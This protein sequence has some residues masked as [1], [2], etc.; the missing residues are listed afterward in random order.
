MEL[1]TI[2]SHHSCSV[3]FLHRFPRILI[4]AHT[5]ARPRAGNVPEHFRNMLLCERKTCNYKY[6]TLVQFWGTYA[7]VEYFYSTTLSRQILCFYCFTFIWSWSELKL[8]VTSQ[9]TWHI[10]AKVIFYFFY[11]TWNQIKNLTD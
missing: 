9:I 7:V 4:P 3:T 8:R 10:R 11:S 5:D 6:G 2:H 1:M